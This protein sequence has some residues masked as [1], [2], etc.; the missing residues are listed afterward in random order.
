MVFSSN[1]SVKSDLTNQDLEQLLS[2]DLVN[3]K[4]CGVEKK[5]FYTLTNWPQLYPKLVW[6]GNSLK[7]YIDVIIDESLVLRPTID[8]RRSVL[9]TTGDMIHLN[10]WNMEKSFNIKS[11]SFEATCLDSTHLRIDCQW[12]KKQNT[13]TY[14][15]ALANFTFINRNI[16]SKYPIRTVAPTKNQEMINTRNDQSINNRY[17]LKCLLFN[18]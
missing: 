18:Y 11:D 8:F 10:N 9:Q 12:L 3:A 4:T 7:T 17:K 2:C 13:N 1:Y 15:L 16:V 14:Y 6:S 5:R